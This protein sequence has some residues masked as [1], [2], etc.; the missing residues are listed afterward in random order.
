MI[1]NQ[2]NSN[3][4][5]V[6]EKNDGGNVTYELS[7]QDFAALTETATVL[8]LKVNETI[9]AD[10]CVHCAE[11]TEHWFKL[12]VLH[13]ADYSFSAN[14]YASAKLYDADGN[15]L[16]S[17]NEDSE[18]NGFLINFTL[19]RDRVYYLR[20]SPNQYGFSRFNTVINGIYTSPYE[21]SMAAAQEIN[22]GSQVTGNFSQD[23]TEQWYKFTV[24]HN[25]RYTIYTTGTL[26]TIGT[27]YDNFGYFITEQDDHE[28]PEGLNFRMRCFLMADT[29]YYVRVKEANK[30]SGIFKFCITDEDVVDSVSITPSE[31]VLGKV[32]TVYE[33]P[34][35][36]D[37][38]TNINGA[39][40]LKDIS[41]KI[42][43]ETIAG[44]QLK[45][46][47]FTTNVINV[48]E[49]GHGGNRYYTMTVVGEGTAKLYAAD[50]DG[51]GTRGECIVYVGGVPVEG[52][53]LE[54]TKKTISVDDS[55]YILSTVYPF[56]AL[57]KKVIWKSSNPSIAVVDEEGLIT[58]ISVGTTT[59]SAT[60]EDGGFCATCVVTIDPRER[61]TVKRDGNF[62]KIIFHTSGKEWLCLNYD[63]INDP[64]NL[65][66]YSEDTY[67]ILRERLNA[68]TY[69]TVIPQN[70]FTILEDP[71]WYT[72]NEKKLLYTLDP[73]GFAAYVQKYGAKVYS[74]NLAE[75]VN[76]KDSV[77]ETLFNKSPKYFAREIN[78]E[79]YDATEDKDRLDI[80]KMLSESESIFGI[81][82]VYDKTFLLQCIDVFLKL[83]AVSFALVGLVEYV[84]AA[85]VC[86][87][88]L[89]RITLCYT[90]GRAL[91]EEDYEKYIETLTEEAKEGFE[92]DEETK[93]E[94]FSLDWAKALFELGN[95][96][97]ELADI[98][99]EKP[100]FY[101]EI[102]A[103]CASDPNYRILFEYNN[104]TIEDV[105]DISDK[106]N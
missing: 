70:N 45:W 90:V 83:L 12:I 106:L 92:N 37:T 104:G 42:T 33:L 63:M 28:S 39:K 3:D 99:A 80:S 26:N 68:N 79:W 32:G 43:P 11:R 97:E 98:L 67:R 96:F 105:S 88:Y 81:H 40:P 8:Q 91:I 21:E 89:K 101:K 74:G 62:N 54:C 38:F 31:L 73:H 19:V 57:N 85:K 53:D 71:K 1:E 4:I 13:E 14:A 29:V 69:K 30:Q 56:N 93:S 47:C 22:I 24:P 23:Q 50:W 9:Q 65:A 60:T 58:G 2:N 16:V 36:P 46:F 20:I 82:P 41:V 55:E 75:L 25:Q 66:E 61:V 95:S 64:E 94:N 52:I 77:F 59:I 10:T 48:T 15:L 100:T 103:Y 5:T 76:F 34:V 86:E 44:K 49:N 84:P 6:E 17:D 102:F 7:P 87:V 35:S 18:S 78:G 72:D 51:N 27:L